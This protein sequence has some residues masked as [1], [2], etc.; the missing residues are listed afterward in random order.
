MFVR[1]CWLLCGCTRQPAGSCLAVHQAWWLAEAG[2][3]G[4]R[5]S[6]GFVCACYCGINVAVYMLNDGCEE[7]ALD[8]SVLLAGAC[9]AA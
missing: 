1:G 7:H 6:P 9:Q 8:S 3:V 5:S 4:R 2:S